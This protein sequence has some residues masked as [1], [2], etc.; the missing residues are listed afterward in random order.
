MRRPGLLGGRGI[1]PARLDPPV[2]RVLF[3]TYAVLLGV[4]LGIAFR[5]RFSLPVVVAEPGIALPLAV[6]LLAGALEALAV[7]LLLAGAAHARSRWRYLAA[8]PGI[9]AILATLAGANAVNDFTRGL[10]D[11]AGDLL[12]GTPIVFALA[13][14]AVVLAGPRMRTGQVFY[15]LVGLC[16]GFYAALV[17]LSFGVLPTYG[18]TA[19]FFS[20]GAVTFVIVAPLFV[21]G[22]DLTEIGGAVA[23]AFGRRIGAARWTQGRVGRLGLVALGVAVAIVLQLLG[24]PSP[25]GPMTVVWAC[26]LAF[27]CGFAIY[28]AR[29]PDGGAAHPHAELGY[30]TVLGVALVLMVVTTTLPFAVKPDPRY[31]SSVQPHAFSFAP[32]PGLKLREARV[33]PT[34]G[35]APIVV[36]FETPS[37]NGDFVRLQQ[38]GVFVAVVG[39]L[40]YPQGRFDPQP[41]ALGELVPALAWFD[42]ATP[43]GPKQADGWFDGEARPVDRDNGAPAT[44]VV[45]EKQTPTPNGA[46]NM[47]WF[48]VCAAGDRSAA[49]GACEGVRRSFARSHDVADVD[50]RTALEF[51]LFGAAGATL[52]EASRRKRFG[53][54]PGLD[55]LSWTLLLAALCGTFGALWGGDDDPF[56]DLRALAQLLAALILAVIAGAAALEAL[57]RRLAAALDLAAARRVVGGALASL[58]GIALLFLLYSVAASRSE[59]S[60]VIRGLVICVALTW[61]LATAGVLINPDPARRHVFPRSSR[62]F[63]FVAYLI[64]VA[65]CVFLFGPFQQTLYGSGFRGFDTE[66]VVAGGIVMM[67]GALVMSR[68]VGAFA[69]LLPARPDVVDA[70]QPGSQS[71]R[72]FRAGVN[73]TAVRLATGVGAGLR[74]VPRLAYVAVAVVLLASA[75]G[76]WAWQ[77]FSW[78]PYVNPAWQFAASFPGQPKVQETTPSPGA[79]I[80]SLVVESDL[81]HDVLA[82]GVEVPPRAMSDASLLDAGLAS[83]RLLGSIRR[84]PDVVV[85]GRRGVDLIVKAKGDGSLSRYRL[86]VSDG[87]LYNVGGMADDPQTDPDMQRFLASFRFV[88]PQGRPTAR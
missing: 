16:A 57:P 5:D 68:S 4:A 11:V 12:V 76:I 69:A 29:R 23:S 83:Q 37:P 59:A 74:R 31:F 87:R 20:L 14:I 27:G 63:C 84:L 9:A 22:L 58:I 49:L 51:L 52:L 3:T 50:A 81:G 15:W 8:A 60:Q 73:R 56:G 28:L 6:V 7:A 30:L 85:D 79:P 1:D 44:I 24:Y 64:A 61:E 13:C 67:G 38:G 78:R 62:M 41:K 54:T 21:V 46:T 17:A 47:N 39:R 72:R 65:D 48:I 40:R 86:F 53:A 19:L 70:N 42:V 34:Q 43:L 25:A 32:P 80:H 66:T 26:L 77:T 45:L 75:A 71:D 55:L 33:D 36:S 82:V 18:P 2:R 88:D 10:S 35:F